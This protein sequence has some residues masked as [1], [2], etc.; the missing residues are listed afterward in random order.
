MKHDELVLQAMIYRRNV[1]ADLES[2]RAYVIV[3]EDTQRTAKD[4]KES[5]ARLEK[6]GLV[7]QVGK[8]WF[9]T[10]EAYKQARGTALVPELKDEDAWILLSLL[11]NH[12]HG[13]SKLEDI[14]ATADGI[15]HAIPLHE[16]IFGALNR[17]D[18]VRLIKVQRDTFTV[19]EAAL[20]LFSK[21]QTSCKKYILDQLDCL[22]RLMNCPC[23]GIHLKA[24]RWRINISVSEYKNAVKSY[25]ERFQSMSDAT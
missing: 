16:E 8:Q 3:R 1:G 17:L 7:I 11:Y 19:T 5:L 4:Y 2:I 15:N 9:L 18:A 22:R 14:I 10:P 24:V 20:D 6:D 12:K 21:V 25:S 13:Q 23:C